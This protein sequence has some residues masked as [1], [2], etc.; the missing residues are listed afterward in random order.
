MQKLHD[1]SDIKPRN[2]GKVLR[3]VVTN[4][5]KTLENG[6]AKVVDTQL[7]SVTLVVQQADVIESGGLEASSLKNCKVRRHQNTFK[8]ES[9][10]SVSNISAGVLDRTPHTRLNSL[11]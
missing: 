1:R 9:P 7:K 2:S 11:A 8:H 3:H 5:S 10:N 6:S 4:R